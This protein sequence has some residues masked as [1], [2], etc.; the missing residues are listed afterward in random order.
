MTIKIPD[1]AEVTLLNFIRLQLNTVARLRLFKNDIVP[2]DADTV[3]SYTEATFPGYAAQ[4]VNAFSVAST[5]GG[6]AQITHA[7]LTFLRGSGGSGDTIYG[8]Y[9]TD[10]AGTTLYYSERDP[11]APVNMS[12]AGNSYAV[13]LLFQFL[14]Q[15]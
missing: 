5:V 14:S 15:F 4:V 13:S 8:Y 1:V 2:A 3:T 11:A 10:A 12:V 7:A 9:L 6:V